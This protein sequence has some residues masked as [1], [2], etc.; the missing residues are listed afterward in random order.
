MYAPVGAN[1]FV[2]TPT[3]NNIICPGR[4]Y[5][6]RSHQNGVCVYKQPACV[7]RHCYAPTG[8]SDLYLS[9]FA[10]KREP[11]PGLAWG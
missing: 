6:L 1:R 11:L 8:A 4:G 5:P 3:P 9:C 10:T 2:T 7:T